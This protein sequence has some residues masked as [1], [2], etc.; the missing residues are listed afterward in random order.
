MRRLLNLLAKPCGLEVSK[1]LG[2]K[3]RARHQF[4]TYAYSQEGQTPNEHL[5]SLALRAIACA[6]RKEID[7]THCNGQAADFHHFNEFPGEHYRLLKALVSCLGPK[8]AVEIGTYTGMGTTAIHQGLAAQSEI[9]TFDVTDWKSFETHLDSS[10]FESRR[11]TQHLS[12]LSIAA[13]FIQ[14]KT[15]LSQA[16]FIFCDGPKDGRFEVTFL[17]LLKSLP[18]THG[19]RVLMLD[20]IHFP[21]MIDLWRSIKSPKLDITSFGHFSGTGLVDLSMGLEF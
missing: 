16:E 12:D 8:S 21:N 2:V 1:A 9:I 11:I 19:S 20:D 3:T 7:T 10:L 18:P 17:H 6:F 14:F 4:L 13:N 5:V 15:L